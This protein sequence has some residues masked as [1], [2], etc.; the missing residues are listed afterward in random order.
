VLN[1]SAALAFAS[2]DLG[3]YLLTGRPIR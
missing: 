1:S 3:Q 2:G